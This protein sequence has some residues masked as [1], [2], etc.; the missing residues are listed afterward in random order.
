LVTDE[1]Q[2][3]PIEEPDPTPLD[4]LACMCP[5]EDDVVIHAADCSLHEVGPPGEDRGEDSDAGE[6]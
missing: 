5:T 6:R 4:E 2:W 1:T 3:E